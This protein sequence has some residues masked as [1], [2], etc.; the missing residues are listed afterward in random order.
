MLLLG[1][2]GGPPAADTASTGEDSTGTS[3]ISSGVTSSPT[4]SSGGED[5]DDESTTGGPPICPPGSHAAESG[6]CE[7]ELTGWTAAGELLKARDHHVTFV[8][9]TPAGV[10]LYVAGGTDGVA[11]LKS[12]ERAKIGADG[13]LGPFG[14][15]GELPEGLIGAGLAQVGRVVVVAGGLGVDNNSQTVAFVG[16]IADD[17]GVTFTSGPSLLRSRYHL[18]LTAHGGYVYAIGGLEQNVDVQPPA[19]AAVADVERAPLTDGELGPF[20]A[21]QPLPDPLTHHA[22][23]VHDDT[24]YLVGG[25]SGTSV[26]TEIIGAELAGGELGSWALAG[27]L[28]EAR[29]TAAATVFLDELYVI[30]GAT[31]TQGGEV[32]TVLRAPF[33][34][35]GAVEAFEELPALSLTRAH[36]HQAPLH[37]GALYS[38]GGSID[39][40]PQ[41]EV[42]LGRLE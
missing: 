28:P 24:L 32:D 37:A 20:E 31:K 38:A 16:V 13:V 6:E 7:A 39:H 8:A 18:T 34:D 23:V 41:S 5:T 22:A 2:T 33:A 14:A 40:V 27:Y 42:L 30:A 17:G 19:Q 25:I 3:D 12:I 4:T 9:E 29:A 1:C 10:F 21:L 35:N 15:A 26:R 11:V 36:A